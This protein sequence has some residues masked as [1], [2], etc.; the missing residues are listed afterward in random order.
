MLLRQLVAVPAWEGQVYPGQHHTNLILVCLILLGF[1]DYKRVCYYTNWSQYRPGKGKFTPDNIIL[2]LI[3]ICLI[4]LGF[5]DYKRVCYYTNWSQYRP[6]KGKFTPD[7]ILNIY[8]FVLYFKF[9]M[10]INEYVTTRTG[11]SIGLG[12]AS[13]PRT[14]SY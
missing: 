13:L 4:L 12:R 11:H 3:L 8:M 5:N 6:R 2:N 9:L 7:I 10:T 1:N 14:T